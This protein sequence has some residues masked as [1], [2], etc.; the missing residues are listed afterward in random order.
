MT[1]MLA[2]VTG[3]MAQFAS[4]LRCMFL[5]FCSSSGRTSDGLM[6]LGADDIGQQQCSGRDKGP[7]TARPAGVAVAVAAY[8]QDWTVGHRS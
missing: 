7:M 6:E 3:D 1:Q 2:I 8:I 5:S 4:A